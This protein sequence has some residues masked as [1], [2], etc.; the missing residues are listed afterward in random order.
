MIKN[1]VVSTF[2][3]TLFLS[4]VCSLSIQPIHADAPIAES[5]EKTNP[6]RAGQRAPSFVVRDVN[7]AEYAFDPNSLETPA[8]IITF[9]GGWCPYCNMHLS[10]LRN[11]V[12]EIAAL[13]IEVLFLSGDRP[14]LLYASLAQDT[15]TDIA[16]LDYQIYSDA[17]SQAAI[18]FGTAFRADPGYEEW[19]QE[20]GHDYKDSSFD[21]GGVLGVPAVYAIDQ[22]GMIRFDFV[23]ADYKVRLSADE[24]LAVAEEIV[25]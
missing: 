10:E 15:Q 16:D 12:P 19:F 3:S 4:L 21:R 9:R 2:A 17:E 6:L 20:K 11:V 23:E 18:A 7:N 8:L 14:E 25:Q 1:L 22:K 5:A 24:L 13:G